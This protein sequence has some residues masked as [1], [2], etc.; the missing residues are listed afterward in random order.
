MI[1]N[2]P[3]PRMSDK[4]LDW[5]AYG[6]AWKKTTLFKGKRRWLRELSRKRSNDNWHMRLLSKRRCGGKLLTK[7]ALAAEYSEKCC[8]DVFLCESTY[9]TGSPSQTVTINRS[10]RLTPSEIVEASTTIWK[11]SVEV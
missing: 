2:K 9:R 10:K 4:P 8:K 3:S 11:T 6:M 7:T 5:R 1:L